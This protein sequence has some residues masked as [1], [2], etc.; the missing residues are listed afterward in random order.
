MKR[1]L[2]HVAG[3]AG[4]AAAAG[5]V[6]GCLVIPVDYYEAGSRHN[7]S[8]KTGNTLTTGLTTKEEIFL[9]LG[10]PDYASEDG[11]RLGYAWTKVKAVW[12]IAG[13]GSAAAGEIQRSYVLVATFDD[14]NRVFRVQLQKAWGPEVPA[15]NELRSAK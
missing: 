1:S 14:S 10:E 4:L 5:L 12:V 8:T 7:L 13:Q 3:V 6:A 15:A 2:R 9:S 11:R